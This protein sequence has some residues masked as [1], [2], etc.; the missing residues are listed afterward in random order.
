[1]INAND[2]YTA[3]SHRA[4]VLAPNLEMLVLP[5]AD[6]ALSLLFLLCFNGPAWNYGE[7]APVVNGVP[8]V[9]V[10]FQEYVSG[11]GVLDDGITASGGDRPLGAGEGVLGG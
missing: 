5:V 1:M 8:A 6:D 7:M 10:Q 3:Y 11:D 2:A 9:L 4:T